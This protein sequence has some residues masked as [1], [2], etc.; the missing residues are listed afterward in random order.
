MT[1]SQLFW[2]LM[3]FAAGIAIELFVEGI[4]RQWRE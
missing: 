3:P 4:K 2:M 1:H